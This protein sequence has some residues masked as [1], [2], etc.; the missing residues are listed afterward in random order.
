[1][2]IRATDPKQLNDIIDII[3][4]EWFAVTDVHHDR[5]QRRVRIP[6]TRARASDVWILEIMNVDSFVVQES[7]G[8]GRYDFNKLAYAPDTG[9]LTVKT[10]IPLTAELTVSHLDVSVYPATFS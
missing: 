9:R 1:M 10:G 8:I 5:E 7:E 6:F 2:I 4:D 3:H